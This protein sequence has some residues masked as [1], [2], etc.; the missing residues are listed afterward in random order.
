MCLGFCFLR[1][2]EAKDCFINM[3]DSLSPLLTYVNRADCVDF[4]ESSM[5]AEVTNRF[6]KRSEMT[7]LTTDYI[8]MQMTSET[9]WEMK[10]LPVDS[11]TR[12]I[13]TVST[14]CASA[15][16]SEIRFYTSDW[17]ELSATRYLSSLPVIEDFLADSL[18][19]ENNMELLSKVD[20]LLMKAELSPDD[21]ALIFTCT[22]PDYR[23]KE[24]AEQL[25]PLLNK[26]V[27]YRWSGGEFRKE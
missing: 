1:A 8:R 19:R 11:V 26:V 4:L 16:D 27:T 13:C 3:P 12:I 24:G 22:T 2:Q 15:C 9:A 17:Q 25:A 18:A 23:E 5:R 14:V 6:G 20:M 21:A 7:R 10:L